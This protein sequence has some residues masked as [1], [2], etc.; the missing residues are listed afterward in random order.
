MNIQDLQEQAEALHDKKVDAII[1]NE[2]IQIIFLSHLQDIKRVFVLFMST[3]LR[4]NLPARRWIRAYRIHSVCIS[5]VLMCMG[6][7]EQ[8]SRSDVNIIAVVNPTT[9]QILLIT[10][11][12]DYYIPIPGIS[13]GMND[14][15]THAGTYGIDVS[16]ER[17]VRCMKRIL[18]IM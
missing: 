13:D 10:T 1:Y 16:M 2:V 12:R 4:K 11:P 7:I 18:T 17:S 14:K 3:R 8:T 6:D 15:L 9:H 5:V